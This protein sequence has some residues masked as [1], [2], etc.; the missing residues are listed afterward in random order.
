MSE[1]VEVVERVYDA[2]NRGDFDSATKSFSQDFEFDFS[3]S[4]GPLSGI[5]RGPDGARDFLRSFYEPWAFLTF[6]PEE[7]FELEDGRVL[8]V[9][10]VRGRGHESGVDVAAAGATIW[11]IRAGE[12][13]AITGYQSKDEALEAA[14]AER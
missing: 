6:D 14:S 7:V 1:R 3:N 5:Y 8:A 10:A 4:R 11:T 2:L 13:V 9:I 12:V